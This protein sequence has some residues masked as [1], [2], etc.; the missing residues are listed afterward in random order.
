MEFTGKRMKYTEEAIQSLEEMCSQ[1]RADP[2]GTSKLH[3]GDWIKEISRRQSLLLLRTPRLSAAIRATMR[4]LLDE[5]PHS[6]SKLN[7]VDNDGQ[8]PIDIA[9][10]YGMLECVELLVAKGADL[11][12]LTT[13][14]TSPKFIESFDA[15]IVVIHIGAVLRRNNLIRCWQ[16]CGEYGKSLQIRSAFWDGQHRQDTTAISIS[17]ANS[18]VGLKHAGEIE[19]Y[20]RMWIHVPTTSVGLY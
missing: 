13:V 20:T 15:Y 18:I 16:N 12:I 2:L 11:G 10:R 19:K 8:S 1:Y 6:D 17:L 5:I 7:E 3:I 4:L 14:Y 9:T